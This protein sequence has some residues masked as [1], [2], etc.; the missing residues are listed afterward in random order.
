[1]YGTH[2]TKPL[3]K[4]TGMQAL[5]T[6]EQDRTIKPDIQQHTISSKTK[7]KEYKSFIHILTIKALITKY[8]ITQKIRYRIR[9]R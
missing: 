4:Y 1:M 7:G 9:I 6:Q 3:G 8:I 2:K 5:V